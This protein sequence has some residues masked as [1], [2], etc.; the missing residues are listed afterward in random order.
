MSQI[1]RYINDLE[2]ELLRVQKTLDM[3]MA[4]SCN[5]PEINMLNY[6]EGEVEDLNDDMT[7][8]F[9]ILEEYKGRNN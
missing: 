4:I 7:Q 3:C 8:I 5:S 9:L 6:G 2:L 1:K